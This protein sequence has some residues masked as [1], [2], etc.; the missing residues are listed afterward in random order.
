MIGQPGAG[1]TMLAQR[2]SRVLPPPNFNEALG[3]SKIFSVA[4]MLNNS[5]LI[6]KRQFRARHHTISNASLVGG[7]YFPGSC[8]ASFAH[9]GVLFLDEFPEPRR[10]V[11]DLLRPAARR[12]S[13]DH[14]QGRSPKAIQLFWVEITG[15]IAAEG[16][17]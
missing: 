13:G 14:R 4:G 9:N 15:G 2:L 7:G 3:T 10:S 17:I 1:K 16:I 6:V 11:L 12:R 8:E 5:P